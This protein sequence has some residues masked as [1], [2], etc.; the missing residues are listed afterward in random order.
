MGRQ[1]IKM[2]VSVFI[3]YYNVIVQLV[4]FLQLHFSIFSSY[5]NGFIHI[6]FYIHYTDI[7][8]LSIGDS[9]ILCKTL[10]TV[11]MVRCYIRYEVKGRCFI[12]ICYVR[13][14]EREWIHAMMTVLRW[15]LGTEIMY[16]PKK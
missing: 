15:S 9:I 5:V 4:F 12:C 2:L 8:C 1:F 11:R 3:V 6:V 10:T 7:C 14:M 16:S 13:L